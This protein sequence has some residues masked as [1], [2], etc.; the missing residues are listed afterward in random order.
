MGNFDRPIVEWEMTV[1]ATPSSFWQRT[2]VVGRCLEFTGRRNHDGYGRLRYHGRLVM[3]HRLAWI[4][5][6][7]EI[8]AGYEIDHVCKNRA[9]VA[10]GHLRKIDG[11]TH[12]IESNRGR[13]GML[14]KHEGHDVYRRKDGTPKCRTCRRVREREEYRLGK[15][16]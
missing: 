4:L 8:D 10:P 1:K 12:A 13:Y 7:G 5:T 9:C 3:A 15:R 2:V 6:Y 14:W 11:S 16:R